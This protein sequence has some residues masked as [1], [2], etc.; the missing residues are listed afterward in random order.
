[1]DPLSMADI[2][3]AY[4]DGRFV[5][6]ETG[7]TFA[8][9]DPATEQ[10]IGRVSLCT[11]DDVD[12]AVTAARAA[13]EKGWR[14]TQAV[15]RAVVLKRIAAGIRAR[16]SELAEV[17]TADS[18]KPIHDNQT[19]D[20]PETAGCFD[21]FADAAAGLGGECYTVP[22]GEF[23]AYSL[24]EPVGVVASV[25]PW[26][27]PLVNAAWKIAPALAAGNCVVYKPA[28]ETSLSTLLLAKIFDEAQMPPGVVNIVTGPGDPTGAALVSHPGVDKVSFTGSTATGQAVLHAAADNITGTVLELGGKSANIVFDD[29]DLDRAVAGA[30]FAVFVNAGQ[31]CTAGSR[32]LVQQGIYDAFIDRLV[33][34]AELI[35]IGDPMDPK[36]RMGPLV[37]RRHLDRVNGF[38]D[39]AR[40]DGARL[41]TGGGRPAGMDDGY[42]LTPTV[43][44][45]V[46]LGT[47][48][49]QQEVFGPV[50]GVYRFEDEA[51]AVRLA[52]ATPYGLAAGVWTR[53][54]TRAKRMAGQ[55]EAGT[56]WVNTYHIVS[57][58]IPF[59]GFKHSG[60]GIELGLEGLRE[61]TRSKNICIDLG[62]G[63]MDYFD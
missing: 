43:F 54:M 24:R 39:R 11:A 10:E 6:G 42:Y 50:V 2:H 44:E 18:G 48:L 62:G 52:N 46:R 35:R 31:V 1:M 30:L 21:Y 38:I 9:V 4:I 28:E 59:S 26:N 40:R 61:Y 8:S 22:F 51:Q 47:E 13:F 49:D 7:D 45:D 60:I 41:R 55:L 16:A 3:T 29:C 33:R 23:Q 5:Q 27:Y 12:R 19:G 34:S 25:A 56:V 20:V 37:S 17:E 63:P 32:L 36:T 57:V 58:G 15:D 53:D 14:G